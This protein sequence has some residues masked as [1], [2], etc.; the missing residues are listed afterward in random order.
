VNQNEL[1]R[2]IADK[3]RILRNHEAQL[4]TEDSPDE[5]LLQLAHRRRRFLS[6]VAL[7]DSD[8]YPDPTVF[9]SFASK[10]G[11][12]HKNSAV[13][14]F[15]EAGFA[16]RTGWDIEIQ[17]QTDKLAAIKN[18]IRGSSS[19]LGI[20][21]PE[22]F[23]ADADSRSC[24]GA[25]VLEEKGIAE[26]YEKPIRLLIDEKIHPDFYL[27][28]NSEKLQNLF[29]PTDFETQLSHAVAALTRRYHERLLLEY[30]T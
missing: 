3:N 17:G 8:P 21:T 25:W 12:P 13:Q 11:T 10:S 9:I 20:M 16:V 19:F 5:S 2:L 29:G 6:D 24:P 22:Y 15:S 7:R 30:V 1:R 14:K 26:A 23:I 27:K 18:H 28:V 4:K